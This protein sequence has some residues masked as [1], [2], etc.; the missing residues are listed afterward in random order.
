MH[1]NCEAI[2]ANYHI[3]QMTTSFHLSISGLTDGALVSYLGVQ[4]SNPGRGINE[5]LSKLVN[6][7]FY[8]RIHLNLKSDKCSKAPTELES[9]PE[10]ELESEPESVYLI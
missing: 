5:T 10:S 6:F 8:M 7:S 4:G 3:V 2:A 1:C 9:E